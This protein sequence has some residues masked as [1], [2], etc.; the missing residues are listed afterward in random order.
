MQKG[1]FND[2]S[3]FNIDKKEW[4]VPTLNI[5]LPFRFGA[6]SASS[7]NKLYIFGGNEIN[8]YSD[9]VLLELLIAK[10]G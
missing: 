5:E 6:S 3:L 4:I 7:K 9:G 8:N 1:I 10:E 2:L